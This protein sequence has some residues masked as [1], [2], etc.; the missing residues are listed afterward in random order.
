MQEQ[1]VNDQ[2]STAMIQPESGEIRKF[3]ITSRIARILGQIVESLIAV[4]EVKI[5]S[6]RNKS[7]ARFWAIHDLQYGRRIYLHS[8]TEVRDWFDRRYY[9]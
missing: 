2:A 7:G 6:L 5:Y 1:S 4:N 9:K 8:E 3:S